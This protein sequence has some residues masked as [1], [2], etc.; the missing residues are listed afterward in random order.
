MSSTR[1]RK[2]SY[3]VP[4]R[5]VR[6]GLEGL[7]PRL[8]LSAA[9]EVIGETLVIT[10]T[11]GPDRILVGFGGRSDVLRVVIDGEDRGRFGPVS[12]IQID[13][14]AGDDIVLLGQ[15]VRQPAVIH[16]G[17]GAD[18]LRGG[19]G[20]DQTFGGDGDD[21]V[22]GS[23]GRDA[24]DAGAGRDRVVTPHRMGAIRVSKAASGAAMPH[25][26]RT[27]T[28]QPLRA[29]GLDATTPIVIGPADLA[30]PSVVVRLRATYEAGQPVALTRAT[31]ADVDRLGELL[32]HQGGVG[33]DPSVPHADLVV[34]RNST[35][36]DGEAHEASTAFLLASD[37][38]Q[39]AAARRIAGGHMLE[40]LSQ[41]LSATAV[42]PETS[43]GDGSSQNLIQIAKS[44][45]SSTVATD[46]YG[47]QVQIVNTVWSLRAFEDNVDLYY[48]LQEVDFAVGNPPTI[49]EWDNSADTTVPLTHSPTVFQTSP[50]TVM[51]A[52]TLTG[53]VSDTVSVSVGFNTSQGLDASV[54]K[55]TT[56]S[57]SK[58]TTVPP[59]DVVN[60]TDFSTGFPSWTYA[61]ND[62][63]RIGE[64]Y[65]VFNQWI[66]SVPFSA[67]T[68]FQLQSGLI[69]PNSAA[70]QVLNPPGPGNVAAQLE[71]KIPIPFGSTF[72]LQDPVV[73]GLTAPNSIL[74]E[75]VV[76]EGG[77]FTIHG[78]GL[79][80]S[81]VTG[82]LIGGV[83]LDS[84]NFQT[85]S[86]TQISVIA[87]D[88]FSVLP[89]T[90]V[91][92]TTQGTSNDNVTIIID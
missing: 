1:A 10:G 9:V 74:G 12:Q 28:P 82:V 49:D 45:M 60:A 33:W 23:A 55:S 39:T 78:T 72:A 54:T 36:P 13:A 57:N 19:S 88:Q 56:I 61:V 83:P 43:P 85:V 2:R 15:G 70:F 79:Y 6:P 75:P 53:G 18:R 62:R 63:P 25:L 64:S 16:G 90:V 24:L 65:T 58:A 69:L 34:F 8:A 66:W 11:E 84:E 76:S 32:G 29:T 67:Y 87:P 27:Y 41:A 77:T 7:E 40:A 22:V 91:V 59:V 37:R 44:S 35:R 17:A 81:L 30:D 92:Q 73:T 89:Q 68:Q 48:V 21:L 47:N 38:P 46:S 50:A 20:P 5:A 4:R 42:V 80:P 3:V 86:D 51:E 52:T 26:F 31:D 71:S 14:G